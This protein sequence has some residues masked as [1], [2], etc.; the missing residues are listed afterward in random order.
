MGVRGGRLGSFEL[1]SSAIAGMLGLSRLRLTDDADIAAGTAAAE[2]EPVTVT[3]TDATEKLSMPEQAAQQSPPP[4]VKLDV[5]PKSEQTQPTPPPPARSAWDMEPAQH[6]LAD[7]IYAQMLLRE[8]EVRQWVP[9]GGFWRELLVYRGNVVDWVYEACDNLRMQEAVLHLAVH[10]LDWTMLAVAVPREEMQTLC[11]ACVL[12]AA[13]FHGPEFSVP[14]LGTVMSFARCTEKEICD[15]ELRVLFA[16]EW[17]LNAVTSLQVVEHH[18][19]LG[20]VVP[21]DGCGDT[22][23]TAAR[24][25]KKVRKL[26][27]FLVL[28]TL[29]EHRFLESRATLCGAAAIAAARDTLGLEPW[30]Q[31]LEQRS[32]YTRPSVATLAE[33]ILE[34]AHSRFPDDFYKD[35]DG[36][37][38]AAGVERHEVAQ[39]PDTAVKSEIS[40]PA[41]PLADF[42]RSTVGPG[43]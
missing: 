4:V 33:D 35:A 16:L 10:Y 2:V 38:T 3:S 12:A 6:E 23:Q 21:R 27:E 28:Q 31:L 24:L 40:P 20:I 18:L 15:M 14:R 5:P 34:Q 26:S 42:D 1:I 29:Y 30:P 25:T 37:W 36:R 7:Q 8:A 43:S 41:S 19:E 13:K 11:M 32:G 22:T 9:C 39:R 17:R